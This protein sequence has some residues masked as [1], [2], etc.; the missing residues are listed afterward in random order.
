[1]K[2]LLILF[3]I[4]LFNLSCAGQ[5]YYWED[6]N[7]S[8]KNKIL[9]SCESKLI[10][11]FYEDKFVPRDDENT[12][13]LLREMVNSNDSIFALS[14]FLLNKLCNKSDGSL[15]EMVGKYCIETLVRHPAY[16]LNYF[17][18]EKSFNVF[19]PVWKKY[20]VSTG[21]ELYF[22]K[23]GTSNLSY[24]YDDIN[25]ILIKASKGDKEK[26]ETY[27]IFW[28]IVNETINKMD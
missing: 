15:S 3:F 4:I 1:M 23:Q 6:Y 21:Y 25:N 18:K 7:F 8:Q 26:E 28:K 19:N 22:K 12:Q 24:T 27:K 10:R 14:F 13:K 5:V 9:S 16:V 17:Y 2:A 11:E 20:A